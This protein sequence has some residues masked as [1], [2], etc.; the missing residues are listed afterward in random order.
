VCEEGREGDDVEKEEPGEGGDE[1]EGGDKEKDGKDDKKEEKRGLRM[2]EAGKC[3]DNDKSLRF[4]G[5]DIEDG[6]KDKKIRTLRLEWRTKYACENVNDDGG[7]HWGF[8]T[9]FIIM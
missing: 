2:L 8:F 3:E 7:S 6:P 1:D 9:W 5:Y 4:C